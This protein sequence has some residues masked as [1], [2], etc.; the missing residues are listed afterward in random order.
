VSKKNLQRIRPIFRENGK[1]QAEVSGRL[2]ESLSGIRVVKGYGAEARESATFA[3]GVERISP[4]M[5]D[6]EAMSIMGA[7][8]MLVLGVVSAGI[9]YLAARQ[10][11]AE[12]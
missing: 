8:S 5:E 3:A 11:F 10:I 6:I 12:A 9:M 4:R 2:I 1:I 7:S